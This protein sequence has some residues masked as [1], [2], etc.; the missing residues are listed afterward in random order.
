MSNQVSIYNSLAD[1]APM[2]YLSVSESTGAGTIRV[3]NI[4]SFT[5][6]YAIQV[7]E[8]GE[9]K[10][11]VQLLNNTS[12]AGTGLDLAGT[13]FHDHPADTPI[14]QIKYDKVIWKLSTSGTAG[15][16]TAITSGTV[17]Y[18]PD[19]TASIYD[20]TAG[21]STDAYKAA[22]YNSSLDVS[23]ANSD[24]IL[25]AGYPPYSLG[26]IRKRIKDKLRASNFIGDDS[27]VNDWVNEWLER[28]TNAAIDANE[29]YAYGTADY[30]F[31]T[32]GIG[33]ITAENFQRPRRIW[34]TYDNG[35]TFYESQRI[36]STGYKPEQTFSAAHPRHHYEG[37]NVFV[38]HPPES[39]GTAR[40]A[41]Y[42][43]NTPLVDDYD[44]L[45]TIMRGYSHSFVDYG[46]G[47]AYAK[48]KSNEGEVFSSKAERT[49]QEFKDRLT[50]RDDTGPETIRFV[51]DVPSDQYPLTR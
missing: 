25:P 35:N 22:F 18:T 9:E 12:I 24:W 15:T 46:L 8:T 27:I 26:S 43:T 41:F 1:S 13:L 39:G 4:N 38:V 47:N 48:D 2:S 51:E 16:A 50:P 44:F 34:V 23:S 10:T 14:Y 45:P 28:M 20:H 6:Q 5:A 21:A 11:E 40:V 30:S 33:T 37:D 49:L 32:D 31:G 3:Q 42:K 7:G 29:D 19:G 17:S 36:P